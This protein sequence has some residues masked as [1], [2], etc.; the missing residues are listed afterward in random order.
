MATKIPPAHPALSNQAR[1]KLLFLAGKDL[2]TPCPHSVG[3]GVF[4]KVKD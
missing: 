4:D 2:K 3:D 1:E